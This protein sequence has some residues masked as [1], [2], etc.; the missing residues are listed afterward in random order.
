[1]DQT[2]RTKL[3]AKFFACVDQDDYESAAV[4]VS[5][6][7]EAKALETAGAL[8]AK[9]HQMGSRTTVTQTMGTVEAGSTIVGA[10]IGRIGGGGQ[11]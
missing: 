3:I 9:L 6:F 1:M 2:T 5:A 11:R 4:V 8:L 7:V 10:R